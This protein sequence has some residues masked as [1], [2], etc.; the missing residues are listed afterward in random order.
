MAQINIA[1]TLHNT[2]EIQGDALNSHVVAHADE[3]LDSTQE[4]KQSEVNA[5]V[6]TAL[7]DRYTKS[8]TYSK[9]QV[10][11]LIT[12]PD[13]QYVTV[14]TYSALPATGEP[15]T[16][17]RVASWD[18]SAV[19]AGKYSEYAWNGTAYQLLAVRSGSLDGVFDI[20]ANNL[21]EGQP[22]QYADLAAAIGT[23]GA[24]V[25]VGVRAGGMQVRFINFST[26]KY[27][28][29][30]YMGTDVTTA[31]TFTD[32]S[33]WQGVD[34]TPT[35]GSQNLVTSGGVERKLN[36]NH[37]YIE[38][39]ECSSSSY[40]NYYFTK[41][42]PKGATITRIVAGN[43]AYLM[44]EDKSFDVSDLLSTL[45]NNV[46]FVTDKTYIGLKAN[47]T[48][49]NAI[50]WIVGNTVEGTDDKID[51]INAKIDSSGFGIDVVDNFEKIE[52][53][54][55][56]YLQSSINNAYMVNGT[57]IY[58]NP[59]DKIS[60]QGSNTYVLRLYK[61]TKGYYTFA[62]KQT[63]GNTI[64]YVSVVDNVSDFV[65]GGNI[66]GPLFP[67]DTLKEYTFFFKED[68]YI[69]VQESQN[70]EPYNRPFVKIYKIKSIED[71]IDSAV[72]IGMNSVKSELIGGATELLN[73][74][75]VEDAISDISQGST[76]NILNDVSSS[77]ELS[78]WAYIYNVDGKIYGQ[79]ESTG[80]RV[81]GYSVNK[82]DKFRIT[83]ILPSASIYTFVA[84]FEG[85]TTPV[86]QDATTV[87]VPYTGTDKTSVDEIFTCPKDGWL[88]IGFNS[89]TIFNRYLG[90]DWRV[91]KYE[92][93]KQDDPKARIPSNLTAVVGD[94]IQVFSR[95]CTDAI[96]DKS[97]NVRFKSQKGTAYPR[98]WQ[99]TPAIGDIG[100]IKL[101][102]FIK[103][104]SEQVLSMKDCLVT[105]KGVPQNPSSMKKIAVF[106]DSLTQGG[107]WVV[108][109]AR[110]LLSND[111]ATPTMPAGNNLSNLKFIGA[112]GSGNARYYGVGGWSWKSYTIAGQP[113]FRF[114]VSGV[115]NIVKGAVYTNNGFSFTVVENNTT[116]GSGNIL[117]TTSNS[118]NIPSAAPDV[119]TKSSGSGD[120]TINYT[121]FE[122]DAGNPLWNA[123]EEKVSFT[124]Y[125]TNIG[126][127]SV[128]CVVFLLGWNSIFTD[129]TEIRPDIELLLD[130]LHSEYPQAKVKIMGLQLPSLNGGLG[131]NYGASD[132][133]SDLY[134][135]I[136]R[137]FT[138]NAALEELAASS[139]FSSYVE[140]VD[141][142][143]Q[144][145][146]E[147]NMPEEE[148]Q[149][150]TRNAK[151]EYLGTNG[152]HPSNSGY[153][154]IA[155]VAYR[156]VVKEYC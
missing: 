153:Y 130:T 113:A 155:D 111:T 13:V 70:A 6:D 71:S 97:F 50:D 5:D 29:C 92:E 121:S 108:E 16:I 26:G 89:P 58:G 109:A 110:R 48:G 67:I 145:D 119:L 60:V 46:P 129:F 107:Q 63:G 25:P 19:D 75:D 150:N 137:V 52:L 32:V 76:E 28:Q 136:N 27:E 64:S 74:G 4:K 134:M 14:A 87:I 146:S 11:N 117:C 22:T 139:E 147:N 45:K 47:G 30:R 65:I 2:E 127:D 101:S 33:N 156:A 42:I 24:N 135:L 152:V 39:V 61:L 132:N 66:S 128:D 151:T 55:S 59:N 36:G 122:A 62:V 35:E 124:K 9:S 91:Y 54:Y 12:T 144:F 140:Y 143:S 31:D 51:E 78:L 93:Q 104:Y 138:Y 83:G 34:E 131:A 85:S 44:K 100:T 103:N 90:Y 53:S 69:S 73:F 96:L 81:I 95:S 1:G 8:E 43:A 80:R 112:M 37:T 116:N 98:Y 125:I 7:A 10:D 115:T 148:V 102:Q 142:A 56:D 94:T 21:T 123:S 126:E 106:G 17:Y 3:I 141:V 79:D 23:N 84:F 40:T 18:G 88:L 77:F 86:F 105:I 68:I 82:G 38:V 49:T 72:T 57:D 120:A 41:P 118:S 99:F 15:D 154:Q 133:W 149:V 114:Q 20:S